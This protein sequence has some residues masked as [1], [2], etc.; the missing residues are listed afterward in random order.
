M[1]S[2]KMDES[3]FLR[4]KLLEDLKKKDQILYASFL[5][6]KDVVK[7][8]LPKYSINF[9]TYT[10]H[11]ISHSFS[12]IENIELLVDDE[13]I[14]T[15][16][17]DELYILLSS[18]ILHDI[19]MC[20]PVD[21]V[22]ELIGAKKYKKLA[23][24]YE[25]DDDI[26]FI[27]NIHH[28]ISYY[29]IFKYYKELKIVDEDYA[30]VIALIA[31]AHR[32]EKIDNFDIYELKKTVRSGKEFVC[33]PYLA[34]LVR[35]GDELDITN[36]RTP[37]IILK[38]FSSDEEKGKLEFEKHKSTRKVS[39]DGNFI[40]IKAETDSQEIYNALEQMVKKIENTLVYCQKVIHKIGKFN[41]KEYKL[42]PSF[43]EMEIKSTGFDPKNIK[44]SYNNEF[45]FNS[46]IS[47]NLYPKK[48][49]AI[50]E[51]M[52]N[53]IDA[54][55][56]RKTFDGDAYKPEI[57][58]KCDDKHIKFIDN[59]IGMDEFVIEHYFSKIGESFFNNN[60]ILPDFESIGR[61]GMG[62]LSYFLICDWFEVETK[63]TGKKPL[64][65]RVDKISDI[66]FL[67]FDETSDIKQGTT[68]KIP[69][70]FLYPE[71]FGIFD[72][73]KNI[74]N[75]FINLEIPV[76]LKVVSATG[77]YDAI[78]K[79]QQNFQKQDF[80]KIMRKIPF[81]MD[82]T[83]KEINIKETAFDN[84]DVEGYIYSFYSVERDDKFKDLSKY[85]DGISIR[86]FSNGLRNQKIT[87]KNLYILGGFLNFKK[88]FDLNLSKSQ[89]L[90][91]SKVNEVLQKYEIELIKKFGM[92]FLP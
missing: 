59:G 28:E 91:S 2:A 14:S 4:S 83:P 86:L 88:K 47:K 61:F 25:K 87:S 57:K 78:L 21:K 30:E 32:K 24:L 41:G 92:T 49:Y 69:I 19:G 8:L 36:K 65:F 64:K 72:L 62:I 22:E 75:F 13:N 40:K 31:K 79:F 16:N 53:S 15:F 23:E 50:R 17:A 37:E 20:I 27:R 48:K 63:K 56:L 7:V 66:N 74:E 43:V 89:I 44:F 35:L 58:I 9:S 54:C 29:F 51:I 70:N 67:F 90:P 76:R 11:S 60:R 38:Y 45:I 85:N 73:H 6:I 68:I 10:D 1:S 71:I 33:M 18:S 39:R 12:I 82:N 5:Q 84:V 26:D 46:F 80:D 42:T 81:P 77:N 3:I 52:Q 34:C 55:W